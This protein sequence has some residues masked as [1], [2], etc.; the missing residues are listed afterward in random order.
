MAT[1]GPGVELAPERKD[2]PGLVVQVTVDGHGF[3]LFPSLNRGHVAI[4]VGRNLLPRFQ[5]VFGQSRRVSVVAERLV[6]RGLIERRPMI[7]LLTRFAAKSGNERQ[8]AQI[9]RIPLIAV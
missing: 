3:P 7:V 8:F 2:G 5:T 6:H 9:L 1:P 4:E